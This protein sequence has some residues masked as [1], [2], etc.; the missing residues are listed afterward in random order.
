[1]LSLKRHLLALCLFALVS[2]GSPTRADEDYRVAFVSIDDNQIWVASADG[3]DAKPLIHHEVGLHSSVLSPDGSAIAQM[4]L[5]PG[6]E[7]SRGYYDLVVFSLADS[8]ENRI[9]TEER[10]TTLDWSPD[11]TQLVFSVGKETWSENWEYRREIFTIQRD[12]SQRQKIADAQGYPFDVRWSPDGSTILFTSWMNDDPISRLY[13]MNVDGSNLRRLTENDPC[14]I[15]DLSTQWTADGQ[16]IIYYLHP[17]LFLISAEGGEPRQLT[18]FEDVYNVFAVSHA[19]YGAPYF[20]TSSDS[21][22]LIYV[23]GNPKQLVRV[24]F[25]P[26][27]WEKRILLRSIDGADFGVSGMALAPDNRTLYFST[28]RENNTA[29]FA[30]MDIESSDTQELSLPFKNGYVFG[31]LPF[32][33]AS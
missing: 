24:N 27:G 11:S 18:H 17:N 26:D 25:A 4:Q 23:M 21:Q 16:H 22:F 12:G 9:V 28:F 31:L 15:C 7:N 8:S 19:R 32:N 13:I 30:R 3:A 6:D 1:M 20:I 29:Y 33:S 5:L 14:F 2:T 10:V